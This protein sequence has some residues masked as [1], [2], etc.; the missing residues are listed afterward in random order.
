M[1]HAFFALGL[2]VTLGCAAADD[3]IPSAASGER[4]TLDAEPM[5][6]ALGTLGSPLATA[7]YCSIN[8][9]NC[10]GRCVQAMGCCIQAGEPTEEC[11]ADRD[12]CFADCEPPESPPPG[13]C[14]LPGCPF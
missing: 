5:A 11:V 1:N 14:H 3:E 9:G 6:D 8:A 12:A 2:L 10:K 4:E 7:Y 13:E